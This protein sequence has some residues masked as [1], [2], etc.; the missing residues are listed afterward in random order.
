[1]PVYEG[2]ILDNPIAIT[3]GICCALVKKSGGSWNNGWGAI[4]N[5]GK[6]VRSRQ[7]CH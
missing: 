1:M 6:L 5:G 3:Q 4:K 2:G 7:F